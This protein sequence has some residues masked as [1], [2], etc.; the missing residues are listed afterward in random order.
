MNT[1]QT[2][3]TSLQLSQEQLL[4]F[5]RSMVGGNRGREDDD[6]PLPAGPWDPVIRVAVE[7]ISVFG[8][9]PEPWRIALGAGHSFG[10]EVAL[11]PQPLP[12]RYALLLEVARV[13]TS[14]AELFQARR[15]GGAGGREARDHHRGWL[16]EPVQR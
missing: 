5:V 9:R 4:T 12:P 16:Y 11:N 15:R 3:L 7:K 8:P 10:E 6:H 14:R 13:V 1:K 2:D